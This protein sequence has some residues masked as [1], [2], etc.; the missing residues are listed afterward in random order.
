M[1]DSELISEIDCESLLLGISK[2][3]LLKD[4]DSE[5]IIKYIQY[6]QKLPKNKIPYDDLYSILTVLIK[7]DNPK[8]SYIV[9][10]FLEFHDSL[11]AGLA[12]ETL[13]CKWNNFEELHEQL[14]QFIL[15]APWDKDQDLKISALT[16]VLHIL[17]NK[18]TTNN[19]YREIY[20]SLAN[21]V[22]NDRTSDS[23]A[24]ELCN[25]ILNHKKT[26]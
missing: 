12:L 13:V 3:N 10:H 1:T 6:A 23:L 15:G 26:T 25:E 18:N 17:S 14:T 22:K 9:S 11:I 16:C 4:Q 20:I 19:P 21:E 24:I 5:S 8:L 7:N 2:G